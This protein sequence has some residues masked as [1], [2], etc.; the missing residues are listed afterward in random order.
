MRIN[1]HINVTC[2]AISVLVGLSRTPPRSSPAPL[3]PGVVL[4]FRGLRALC[5]EFIGEPANFALNVY[6]SDVRGFA[7]NKFVDVAQGEMQNSQCNALSLF[8]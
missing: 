4:S 1:I 5:L 3:V 8:K 6:S 2:S 7:R